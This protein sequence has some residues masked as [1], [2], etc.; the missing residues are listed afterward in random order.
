MYARV[1]MCA[2]VCICMHMCV[3]HF[4]WALR[5]E[6]GPDKD[7]GVKCGDVEI[8][9]LMIQQDVRRTVDWVHN[10]VSSDV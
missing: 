2:Y 9:Y 1:H 7:K 3:C 4:T 8:S 5:I 10:E 6:D